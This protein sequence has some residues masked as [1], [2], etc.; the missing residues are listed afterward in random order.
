MGWAAFA[1][2][3]AWR[4]PFA[5]AD[6]PV[7]YL[8]EIR[9][10]LGQRCTSCHGA[11]RKQ[12]GLRLDTAVL[13]RTGGDGGPAVVAGQPA[14]SLLLDAVRGTNGVARMP[15]EGEPL[16]AAEIGLLERWIQQGAPAPAEVTPADPA[17]HWAFQAPVRPPLPVTE[18]AAWSHNPID[19][20]IAAAQERAGVTSS[21][22][23]ERALLLRRVYFD[24]VG[25][26]PR[27][28][29]LE[30]FLA[31]DRPDAFERVVDRLLESPQYGE[32]WGRHLM[33]VW[34]YSDW[35][36][37]GAE[38]RESKPHIWRWRDWI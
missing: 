17:K 8:Q 28:Q 2:A 4:V 29:E 15:P 22:P 35:D 14:E 7:D 10:L 33:D 36:G 20:F 27:P 31:D 16:T 18:R 24:L 34:R 37:Y 19:R 38:V 13:A 30:E 25:L 3:T 32:R 6:E 12:N 1:L 5:R 21:P 23:A 26:P 9:P 11:V